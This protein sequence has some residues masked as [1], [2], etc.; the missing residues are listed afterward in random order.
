M[1]LEVRCSAVDKVDVG[2][3]IAGLCLIRRPGQEFALAN[4]Q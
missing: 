3:V 4:S 1:A 2:A